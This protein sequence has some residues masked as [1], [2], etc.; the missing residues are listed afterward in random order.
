MIGAITSLS[1]P[2]HPKS[3]QSLSCFKL[4][5]DLFTEVFP[6]HIVFNRNHEILQI[7]GVLQQIY[8]EL[9]VGNQLE[10]HFRIERPNIQIEFDLI[11][12][13]ARSLF[14][15]E[16]LRNGMK[17]KGQMVYVEQPEAIFFL[18]SPWVTDIAS[19][20]SYGLTLS[21]FAIH[22]PVVDFLFLLQAQ[23]TALSD[24][25]KLTDEL[26]EQR[27][28]LRKT[29]RKLAALY[30]VT[31]ILA[32]STTFSEA[33]IK[34]LEAICVALD[35]QVG[36]LWMVDPSARELK[37]HEV[38]TALPEHFKE[39]ELLNRVLTLPLGIGLA[40]CVWHE[41]EPIWIEDITKDPNS[42]RRLHAIAARLSGGFGL[43]IR[44][45]KEVIGVLEFLAI[46]PVNLMTVCGK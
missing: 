33:A 9:A 44:N 40:G 20:K 21:D 23:N 13:R 45:G 14:L 34:L 4:I 28:A 38:W 46:S 18:C 31:H 12:K 24:A 27:A 2:S 41:R 15:L 22:D 3:F 17:L 35:W 42:P 10:H 32:E 37:C 5:P 25:K 7:G 26:T 36:V 43:P 8:P 16:S 39:F 19:L 1:N 6:F 11:R 30:A 29:N